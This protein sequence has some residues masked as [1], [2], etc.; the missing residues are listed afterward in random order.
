LLLATK[1]TEI[2]KVLELPVILSG[3]SEDRNVGHWSLNVF[4][5][6]SV[7]ADE[8][9]SSLNGWQAH[10][11]QDNVSS[12]G[13]QLCTQSELGH[14]KIE[15][16]ASIHKDDVKVLGVVGKMGEGSK[17]SLFNEPEPFSAEAPPLR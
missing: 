2:H 15:E 14:D 9:D 4:E 6:R 17:G 5:V 13:A 12:H 1:I 11:M 10:V 16:M 8:C 7:C 3:M